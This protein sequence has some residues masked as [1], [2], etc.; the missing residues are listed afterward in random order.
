[1]YY[2]A[3]FHNIPVLG[4]PCTPENASAFYAV[5]DVNSQKSF[6][7]NF[8]GYPRSDIAQIADEQNQ[9]VALQLMANLQERLSDGFVDADDAQLLASHRSRY[10]QTPSEM[11]AFVDNVLSQRDERIMQDAD[12]AEKSKIEKERDERRRL[13][14][15]SLSS[16]ERDDVNSAKR[17]AKLAELIFDE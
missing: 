3:D 16:A 13:L 17:R 2:N 11:V 12:D 7:K 4:I 14:L 8:G 5:L 1:M 9:E 10:C 15:E 6:T